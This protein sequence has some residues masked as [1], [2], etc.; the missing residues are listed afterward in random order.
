MLDLEKLEDLY[1][2]RLEKAKKL[3]AL[4]DSIIEYSTKDGFIEIIEQFMPS[5][6]LYN[7]TRNEG[8][9]TFRHTFKVAQLEKSLKEV[10]QKLKSIKGE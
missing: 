4:Q 8:V 3:S 2:S 6:D 9:T 5:Y 1:S 7:L 10:R